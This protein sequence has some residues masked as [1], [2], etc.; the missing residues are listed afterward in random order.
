MALILPRTPQRVG[1]KA[2]ALSLLALTEDGCLSDWVPSRA[3]VAA[4]EEVVCD[5]TVRVILQNIAL[6]QLRKL[7]LLLQQVLLVFLRER[8]GW[9]HPAVGGLSWQRAAFH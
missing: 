4:V 3:F 1:A 2:S 8:I 5:P 7:A 6:R 9:H